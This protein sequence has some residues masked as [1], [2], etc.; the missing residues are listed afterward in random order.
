MVACGDSTF[1]GHFGGAFFWA[2]KKARRMFA[3]TNG[4]QARAQDRGQTKERV[5][6]SVRAT[7][8]SPGDGNGNKRKGK[9]ISAKK[10]NKSTSGKCNKRKGGKDLLAALVKRLKSDN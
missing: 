9:G 2:I 10:L 7:K 5:S 8:A 6:R 3:H 1:W 4:V